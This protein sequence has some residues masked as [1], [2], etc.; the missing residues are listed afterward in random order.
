MNELATCN[1]RRFDR[2]NGC[3]SPSPVSGRTTLL[4]GLIMPRITTQTRLHDGDGQAKKLPVP[5]GITLADCIRAGRSGADEINIGS[6]D[7]G[8]VRAGSMADVMKRVA[9]IRYLVKGWIPFGMLTMILAPP[10]F[11][12]SAFCLYALVRTVVTGD[13]PWFSGMRG[14]VKPGYVLWCDT[15]GTAAI[16][17]QRIKDWGLPPERI[18]VPYEDDPLLS[19]NL[20]CEA[21]LEQIEAV[22]NRYRIKLVVIDSLRGAHGGDENSSK[23]ADVLQKLAA[24][25]E[26]TNTAIIIVHHTRKMQF[27][28][29][30]SADSSRGSNAI[31][32]MV[33]SQLGIDKP[34]KDGGWWRLQML[35]E[36]LGLKPRPIGFRIDGKG[37]EFG[38][39]PEK[40]RKETQRDKAEDWLRANMEPGRWYPADELLCGA[41]RRRYSDNAVQRAREVLGIVKPD[42]VRKVKSGWEWK[43]SK[44]L[45][46]LRVNL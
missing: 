10:G 46:D 21:H 5:G 27:D 35:K 12:K 22:V 26:R 33:R 25:A 7:C 15:E 13:L 43:L 2:M 20:A 42:Y 38:A 23:V 32:A 16:T 6:G 24:I 30:L 39:A 18:K 29:E 40:P 31:V 37:L 44:K 34:D 41:K 8:D 45:T 3:P 14:P 19:V 9:G 28:E 1:R 17:V 4:K 36:N 11:G